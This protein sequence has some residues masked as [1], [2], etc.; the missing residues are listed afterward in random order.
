MILRLPYSFHH[1]VG[2]QRIMYTF[3]FTLPV[4]VEEVLLLALFLLALWIVASIP[5][6]FSGKIITDGEADFGSAMGATLGGAMFYVIVLWAGTFPLSPFL[7]ASALVIS[8]ALAVL[9]W[10]AVYR[11]SINTSWLGA[12]RNRV[13][14]LA[15]PVR[16]G[17]DTDVGLRSVVPEVLSVLGRASQGK[18]GASIALVVTVDGH[19]ARAHR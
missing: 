7:G 17:R 5:V 6:Y 11:S 19:G 12:V 4:T 16:R 1:A 10:L 18:S 3:G 9:A 2:S 13:S 14:R 15:N 8:F